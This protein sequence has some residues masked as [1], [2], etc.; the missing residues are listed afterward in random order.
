ML[1]GDS[2]YSDMFV[3]DS[4]RAMLLDSRS[5]SRPSGCVDHK[6]I[7]PGHS[8]LGLRGTVRSLMALGRRHLC[9]NNFLLRC[10]HRINLWGLK[11]ICLTRAE[12]RS[13]DTL[14]VNVD[15]RY[16]KVFLQAC[17]HNIVRRSLI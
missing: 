17:G 13:L 14:R 12:A 2:A 16:S 11:G 9:C 6:E 15:Y 7:V 8:V 3:A 1:A 4:T 5:W 10:E